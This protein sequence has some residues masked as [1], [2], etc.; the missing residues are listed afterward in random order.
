MLHRQG[1][2]GTFKLLFI[3]SLG[4]IPI[5]G[6]C[7]GCTAIHTTIFTPRKEDKYV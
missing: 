5:H 7:I 6:S 1:E 2:S 4:S 3:L